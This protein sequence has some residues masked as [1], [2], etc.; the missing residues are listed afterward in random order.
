[1]LLRRGIQDAT[2]L[3]VSGLRRGARDYTAPRV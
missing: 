3:V 1:M 2:E